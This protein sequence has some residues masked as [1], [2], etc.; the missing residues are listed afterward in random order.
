[1]GREAAWI[2]YR[3]A[4]DPSTVPVLR[5]EKWRYAEAFI[6]RPFSSYAYYRSSQFRRDV[7]ILA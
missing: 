2:T 6:G 5:E 3:F 7:T 1:M 4:E